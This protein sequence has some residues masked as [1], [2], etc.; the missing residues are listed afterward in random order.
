M[1]KPELKKQWVE[2]LRS[3]EYK[4][5]E[6]T[7]KRAIKGEESFC[8]LGVLCD[9]LDPEGWKVKRTTSG[10]YQIFLHPL[11]GGFSLNPE[12]GLPAVEAY[13]LAGMNDEGTTFNTIADIIEKSDL[14]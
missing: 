6:G 1:M 10:N 12:I 4:Q 14:I 9:I 8:C 2:A 7:F 13:Q 11:G 3:G 5:G